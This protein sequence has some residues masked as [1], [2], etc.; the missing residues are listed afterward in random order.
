MAK[1]ISRFGTGFI[2][3]ALSLLLISCPM[4]YE[5]P[6]GDEGL[7]HGDYFTGPVYGIARGFNAQIR[8]DLDLTN[9]RITEVEI[10]KYRGAETTG[11]YEE[12]FRMARLIILQTNNVEFDTLASATRT[13]NGIR[14]AGRAALAQIAIIEGDE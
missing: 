2:F 1:K 8:V 7:V 9:G 12:P 11:W 5:I 3:L 10:S 13:T 14:N 6:G 4:E